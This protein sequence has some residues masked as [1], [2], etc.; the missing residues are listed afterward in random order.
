MSVQITEVVS[1][2]DLDEFIEVPYRLMRGDPAFVPPLRIERRQV[3]GRDNPFFAHGEAT[4]F[5]A[6]R[7][8]EV[9][10][11][12]SAHRNFLHEERYGDGAGFFG[13]FDCEDDEEAARA[14]LRA[15]CDHLRS[16]GCRSARGPFS[17][18]IND[19]SGVLVE[20]FETPP[21]L[22]MPHNPRYYDRLVRA[23]GFR[24]AKDLF[25]WAY[26]VTRP[27]PEPARRVAEAVRE[28]PGLRVRTVRRGR[29]R[30]DLRIIL[31]VFN[32][33]WSRNWGF[34]PL[35]EAEVEHAASQMKWFLEPELALI[36]EVEGRP[37][38]ISL[39]IPNVNEALAGLDGR[40]FPTGWLRLL[41]R[42]KVRRPR[43]ARLMLLG[44]LPEF[45]GSAL[46]GL[47][48]LL[49]VEEHLRCQRL[50]LRG[51][52]LSW[53][54]EDNVKINTGIELMGGTVYK[55]YRV[56]EKVVGPGV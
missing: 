3:L 17:F 52:E 37:A 2:R 38:A 33:A 23:A 34:L 54:L 48:V 40:L 25:A 21:Y 24:K 16:R 39:A 46:G 6:R 12:V 4:Y 41:W 14:L 22:M 45:R 29:L 50:G 26:D 1:R 27:V 47:S 19:E 53:T 10:G 51:G 13:F 18:S 36:A 43:T 11:R 55:R 49:Y 8:G 32:E 30:E 35:T 5:L 44:V 42:L 7:D 28:H 31:Q 9:V 20:G 15:A 56:Y